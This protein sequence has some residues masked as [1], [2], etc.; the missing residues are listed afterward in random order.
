MSVCAWFCAGGCSILG[1]QKS[2]GEYQEL[3]L[4]TV[5]KHLIWMPR[6]TWTARVASASNQPLLLF[7]TCVFVLV[8]D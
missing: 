5:V 2:A 6:R 1:C 7:F 3:E 4:W 8:T